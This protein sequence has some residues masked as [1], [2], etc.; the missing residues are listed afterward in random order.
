[1]PTGAGKSLLFQ[2]PGVIN[3]G[4]TVVIS[5]LL[6][7]IQDQIAALKSL[8]I[9]AHSINSTHSPD[10]IQ[11]ITQSIKKGVKRGEVKF[12]YVTPER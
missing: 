8:G 4:L 7:L 5:P 3:K 9:T 10:E 2:L 1:M 6:S 12:V 11:N